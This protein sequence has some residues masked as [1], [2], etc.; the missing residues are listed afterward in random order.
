MAAKP[1]IK[2]TKSFPMRGVTQVFSNRYHFDGMT[3]LTA[4]DWLALA[5]AIQ[6]LERSTLDL[7]SHLIGY[8]GYEAGSDVPV[9]SNEVN[10]VG[11]AT[12]DA[13]DIPVPGDTAALIRYSTTQRTSKNHPVYLFNYYHD[14][15]FESSVGA[16]T[17]SVQFKSALENLASAW[18][19]GFT[20]GTSTIKR[21]GPNGAVAQGY[22][23]EQFLTHRDFPR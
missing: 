16:D 10:L 3:G 18:V 19:T 7:A 12:Y 8:T 11:T 2:V 21:C 23:V 13:S 9:Y 14:A 15:K 1:S 6:S 17:I 20:V 22:L 4:S 5:N